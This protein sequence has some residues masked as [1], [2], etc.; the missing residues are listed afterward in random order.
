MT[1]PIL[2]MEEK[3]E[4]IA[5][6]ILA[7]YPRESFFLA[8]KLP[9]WECKTEDDVRK[10]FYEQ[11]KKCQTTYFDFYLIHAVNKDRLKQTKE[12]N[13]LKILE[14][15]RNEGKIRNIRFSFHDDLETFKE[16]VNLYDWD[17]VQIQLNYMDIDHQQGIEGYHILTEKI[18]L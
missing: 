11:L 17:F 3:S 14:E 1:P 7:K 18:F 5:G 8:D 13:V 16:W 2:I 12:L 9:L 10:V 6:E 15:F 4:L